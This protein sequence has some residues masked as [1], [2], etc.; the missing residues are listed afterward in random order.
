[1]DPD[2]QLPIDSLRQELLGAAGNGAV[3]V[4]APTGS[5]KSTQVPRWCVEAG[6]VLV[7]EPRRV[8]CRGLAQ[9]VA[10]LEGA[11][12]GEEVGYS[13]RDDN[14]SNPRT[15]ILFATPGVVLRWL[16]EAA[17]PDFATIILDEF[18]ERSL[19]VD[20]LLALLKARYTG[21]LIVMSATMQAERVA[22][23]LDGTHI[24]AHGRTYPVEVNHVKGRALL[25]D[26]R[27]LEDRLREALTRAREDT[28]DVLVF[29]PGKGEISR[30]ADSLR[31]FGGF[32]ILQIH[33]GLS[34]KEQS[35]IFAP[36]KGRRIIL[37]TNV[38]E[39]SI[40]IPR[41]GIVI[42]SGLVRRTRYVNG[43]GFLTLVP[44]AMD[45]AEQRAGRAGRTAPGVCYRLW[46]ADARLE[47][48]TPPE[49]HREA[50]APLLLAA[51]A[52]GARPDELPFLDPP[53]D[54]AADA[55]VADLAAI[56]ALDSNLSITKRGQRLFGLPLD[57]SLGSL[58]VE[59]KTEGC[60]ESVIDL[61][62]GLAVGR[63]VFT[64]ENRP[65]DEEDDLRCAGCD[66]T[67]VIRAVREGDPG[68]HRLNRYV[69]GEARSIS[70]RLRKAFRLPK[71]SE[72]AA[73]IHLKKII[74]AA[75]R[76]DLRSAYVARRRRGRVFF[77]N[78]GPEVE[79]ARESAVNEQNVEGVA[80]LGSMAVGRGYRDQ[81]IYATCAT[82][83]TFQQIA[84]AGLGVDHIEHASKEG[85]TL[86][87]RIERV[88][89][90]QVIDRREEVPRGEL[91][92]RAA[93]DMF[94]GGRL[95]KQSLATTQDRLDAA[96]LF[97]ALR[98]AGR[99]DPDLTAG[100]W[101]NLTAVP[102]V[103]DW[104]LDQFG[105]LGL[106]SGDDLALLAEEDLLAPDLPTETR[107][108]LDNNYPRRLALGDAEYA[109]SYDFSKREATL[110]L[111]SG[112]RKDPPS[113]SMLPTLSGLRVKARHHSRVWVLRER[114]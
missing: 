65:V 19:D 25:P 80:V 17:S 47:P 104:A 108:W 44:V 90:G 30:A 60:L 13:V 45:S 22:N 28:G 97:L 52:C 27:G 94:T 107:S 41:I 23:H 3:V 15:Q 81:R 48:V 54:Y 91:A 38:A 37:A 84:A 95:F 106:S 113:T 100:M 96:R 114:R 83:L 32:D 78:G 31:K 12:L 110:I 10:E 86:V 61:V 68:R 112:R 58:I 66:V 73:P 33:G 67:A 24:H 72:P 111:V 79:L 56:G 4:T 93:A 46:S 57:A 21:R 99:T 75:L 85:S 18:H 20:L 51:A 102:T 62:A 101:E 64:G 36:S 50:L 49:I 59:A 70:R 34:L 6:R 8:A 9:R 87:V 2:I 11:R 40:T 69:L 29:L 53:K 77:G 43:R 89:A 42:D 63:P 26:I 109:I 1:M 5:G 92:R 103:E 76:A 55:A 105:K 16:V 82:P 71:A 35:H 14:R 88:F 74:R 98:S 39:T 7:I